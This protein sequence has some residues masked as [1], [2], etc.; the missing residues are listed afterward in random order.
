MG[1]P[2][3]VPA[4]EIASLFSKGHNVV[5]D[6]Q[7]QC[8]N[9]TLF[10]PDGNPSHIPTPDKQLLIAHVVDD[11][12]IGLYFSTAWSPRS[13]DLNLCDFFLWVFPKSVVYSGWTV[14]T[15]EGRA[16]NPYHFHSISS[17]NL[18]YVVKHAV[19]LFRLI[20]EQGKGRIKI[21]PLIIHMVFAS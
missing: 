11:T 5:M 9:H 15:A 14:N 17:D 16:S 19:L 6:K 2:K 20:A 10:M 1:D 21:Y 4:K 13:P 8:I 7:R 3:S 18:Q 12:I